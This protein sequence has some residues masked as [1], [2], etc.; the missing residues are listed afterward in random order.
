[1]KVNRHN[2]EM[3]RGDSRIFNLTVYDTDGLPV[4]ITGATITFKLART[5][6]TALVFSKEGTIVTAEEG[7]AKITILANETTSFDGDYY[8]EVEVTYP[9]GENSTVVYGDFTFLPDH[10]VS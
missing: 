7:T 4:D 5:R 1:M 3:M 6:D 2:E 10:R 9:S 8:Y